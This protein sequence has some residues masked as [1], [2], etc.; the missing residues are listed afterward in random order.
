MIR[1]N[2]LP[3]RAAR[4]KE[5]IRRQVSVFFLSILFTVSL[6]GYYVISM[7]RK[8]SDL[9]GKI[10]ATQTELKRYQAIEERVKTIKSQLEALQKKNDVI[11]R[12]EANRSGPVRFMD[13]LTN[14]VIA[15]RMW[16]ASL[17]EKKGELKLGGVATDNK[18]IADFMTRLE[19]SPCFKGVDLI[20]SKQIIHKQGNNKQ[21]KKFKKFSITC[22]VSNKGPETS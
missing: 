3:V 16:L 12:L 9:T 17:E 7:N 8:I 22:K 20:S 21:H 19:D 10:E 18:T 15:D 14:V 5:N 11:T 4:K 2:L 13:A 6:M 1:I